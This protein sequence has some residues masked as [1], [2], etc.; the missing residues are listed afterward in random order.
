M[1]IL[2]FSYCSHSIAFV[3]QTLA[4]LPSAIADEDWG[5]RERDKGCPIGK[6]I[7]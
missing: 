5:V 1:F 4:L 6:V 7:S 2:S 3:L